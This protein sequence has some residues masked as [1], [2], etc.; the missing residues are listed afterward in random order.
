MVGLGA[1]RGTEELVRV[2]LTSSRP[3]VVSSSS[4]IYVCRVLYLLLH[5]ALLFSF[6]LNQ[7]SLRVSMCFFPSVLQAYRY[8]CSR[9]S[10]GGGQVRDSRRE[11]RHVKER[12]EYSTYS[13]LPTCSR[14]NRTLQSP[15]SQQYQRNECGANVE[16]SDQGGSGPMYDTTC[17]CLSLRITAV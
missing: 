8:A 9:A 12:V 14:R 1:S 15:D 4:A 2:R 10:G 16:Q 7:I 17:R 13:T 11:G 6:S 3:G 5:P